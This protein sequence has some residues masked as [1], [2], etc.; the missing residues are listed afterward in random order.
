MH[1]PQV[2]CSIWERIAHVTAIVIGISSTFLFV[3]A[4]VLDEAAPS[5]T[6]LITLESRCVHVCTTAVVTTLTLHV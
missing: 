6:A 4:T 2:S 5:N 1:A 3:P